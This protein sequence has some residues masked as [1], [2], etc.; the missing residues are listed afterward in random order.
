MIKKSFLLIIISIISVT[1]KPSFEITEIN[2]MN[3]RCD[4]DKSI[5]KFEFKGIGMD[6]NNPIRIT[7][8]LEEPKGSM[9]ICMVGK[10]LMECTLDS[11]IYDL[12]GTKILEVYLDE[13]KIPNLD[14]KNWSSFFKIENKRLNS[15]TNCPPGERSTDVEY[16]FAT[17]D[18]IK[19]N[20]LG[21]FSKKINFS[22]EVEKLSGHA[23]IDE[24]DDTDKTD[25][26]FFE[27]NFVQPSDEI[28]KCVLTMKSNKQKYLV[29]C[30]LAKGKTL[31]IGDVTGKVTTLKEKGGSITIRGALKPLTDLE[32]C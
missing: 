20:V 4:Y 23:K 12:S 22:F 10:N 29:N 31:E 18:T 21:C 13:P 19:V 6:I 15:A 26:I 27:I 28:A 3:T 16:I 5:F 32:N 8:P 2:H 17:Y 9:A 14:L 7:L 25:A 11:L 24:I 1:T 30:S